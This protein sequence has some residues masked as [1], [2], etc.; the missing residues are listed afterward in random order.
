[1]TRTTDFGFLEI[2][3][4]RD[5]STSIITT[6]SDLSIWERGLV[7]G[8]N[9]SDLPKLPCLDRLPYLAKSNRTNEMNN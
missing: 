5:Y 1:M 9:K 6:P 7:L 3:V 8:D 4:T 2:L